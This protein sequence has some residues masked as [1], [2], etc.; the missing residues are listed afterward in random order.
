M[1][2]TNIKAV[3][4]QF[5]SLIDFSLGELVNDFISFHFRHRVVCVYVY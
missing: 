4:M 1:C 3:Y 5:L 2:S